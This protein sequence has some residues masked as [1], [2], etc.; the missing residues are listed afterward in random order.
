MLSGL[1]K[2]RIG[3]LESIFKLFH[4]KATRTISS[5]GIPELAGG[6]G[7]VYGGFSGF[8]YRSNQEN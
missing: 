3:I 2:I 8:L 1:Q 4:D 6:S 5:A 7:S